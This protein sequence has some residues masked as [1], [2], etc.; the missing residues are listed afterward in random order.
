MRLRTKRNRLLRRHRRK[1]PD[2]NGPEE[3]QGRRRLA[4]SPQPDRDTKIPWVHRLLPLL[5]PRILKNSTPSIRPDKESCCLALGRIAA[6]SLRRV[7]NA[8]VLPSRPH[9]TKLRKAILPSNRCIRL[10]RG[11]HTV[12]GG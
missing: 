2:T 8:Y 11:R 12:A 7:E 3:T 1:R 4:H 5:R 6:Q 10:W 9:S